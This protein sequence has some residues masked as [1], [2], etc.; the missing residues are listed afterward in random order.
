VIVYLFFS[1]MVAS[2]IF[3]VAFQSPRRRIIIAIGPVV[4]GKGLQ[5]FF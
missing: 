5:I 2:E 4:K 1:E 3:L